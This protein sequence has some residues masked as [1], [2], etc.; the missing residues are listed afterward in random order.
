[1][2]GLEDMLVL[3]D[4]IEVL[5][6]DQQRLYLRLLAMVAR[7]DGEIVEQERRGLES[8]MGHLQWAPEEREVA[9]AQWDSQI[10]LGDL[11]DQMGEQALRLALRDAILLSACDGL[12]HEAELDAIEQLREAAGVDDRETRALF[13]WVTEYW[14]MAAEGRRL[15]QMPLEG[16]KQLLG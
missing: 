9:R 15:I 4:S 7:A 10:D 3:P 8:L 16:D 12:Y 14:R 13:R 1:M 2:V 5:D 6:G 11:L